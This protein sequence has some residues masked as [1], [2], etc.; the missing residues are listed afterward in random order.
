MVCSALAFRLFF[1]QANQNSEME[2][3]RY[4]LLISGRVQ[5]V[6]YRYSAFQMAQQL[7]LTG[8]VRNLH[9]GRVE[10]VIEGEADSLNKMADWAAQGPRFAA[11]SH[12]DVRKEAASGEFTGFEIR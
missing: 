7:A 12:V 5:G 11:V 8:W 10:L 1:P 2:T 9:D 4:T 3:Q 6:S